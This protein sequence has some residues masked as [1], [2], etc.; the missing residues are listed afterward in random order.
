MS[1]ADWDV[2]YARRE[3]TTDWLAIRF[4]L[5]EYDVVIYGDEN[6]IKPYCRFPWDVTKPRR[7]SGSCIINCFRW[8]LLWR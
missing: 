1:T 6:C 2:K 3:P 5:K 4:G 7:N 8:K